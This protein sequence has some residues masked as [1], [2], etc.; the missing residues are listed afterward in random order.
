[1]TYSSIYRWL[2]STNA[3]D[4]GTLYLVFSIFAGMIGTAFSVLIRLELANPGVQYLHGDNQLYNVI[5]TA[6]AFIMIFFMVMPALIG[7]FGNYFVPIMIGAPDMAF[8]RLNNISFWLLPPSLILLVGSAFVE[9]GAG[10]GWTVYPPLSSIG[11]HSGGS[12]DLAIFSLHLAGISSM[13]GAINFITTILNMRAPGL[14]M[15]KLPLFVWAVLITAVLLLLSLPVLAGVLVLNISP[16]LNP[17]ICWENLLF[18][19]VVVSQSA[20]N[21]YAF[22]TSIRILRDYTT[23]L[24]CRTMFHLM[25]PFSSSSANSSNS[26]GAYLAG[27]IEGD[28]YIFAPH[29]PL[30]RDSKGRI[31]YPSIQIS[32]HAKDLPLAL[33]MQSVLGHGSISKKIG[34]A[35]VFAINNLDGILLVI[36]LVNGHFR[37][38]KLNAF[39]RLLHHFNSLGHNFVI[40]SLDNSPIL[41]NAWLSGFIDAD[42]HFSIRYSPAGKSPVKLAA[43]F[44]LVQRIADISGGSLL[45]F[46]TILG[47]ALN[48]AVKET[49]GGTPKVGYRIRTTSLAANLLLIS[50]LN[51]F[52][53]FS[54]KTLDFMDWKKVVLLMQQG[55]HKTSQGQA[56]IQM[57]KSGINDSRTIFTWDHLQDFYGLD[58]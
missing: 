56:E 32:F 48:C 45:P 55:S 8:P 3:K 6:H 29:N 41:S 53:L 54:A 2:F 13:L 26:F 38:P 43:S 51:S 58:G 10:T 16:A 40:H 1:M 44:E 47:S 31:L 50:Y 11:F 37:T 18:L 12:V 46:M 9:Q 4:I 15:H 27:L 42:G 17:S 7:G 36:S 25:R 30:D 14:T 52:P 5:I 28:G 21:L 22:V 33:L 34:K 23:G 57:I 35:Y 19:S 24:I 39:N 49:R 20:G